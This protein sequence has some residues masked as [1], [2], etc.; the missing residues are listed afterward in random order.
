LCGIVGL[1]G[2]LKPEDEQMFKVLLLLD[3]FRGQDSTGMAVIGKDKTVKVLKTADDPIILMQHEDFELTLHAAVSRG[4]LGHNRA[5]TI[6]GTSRANAHPFTHGSITGVHNGTLTVVNKLE[7]A[8]RLEESYATDSETLYAHMAKYGV[9][10][11]IT[12]LEGAWALVWFNTADNTL[13]MI[14]NAE[15]PLW[16]CTKKSGAGSVMLWAS[17]NEMLSAAA[18]MSK[19]GGDY[20]TDEEGYSYYAL[21]INTL[22]TWN[23]EM[24][25]AGNLTP[26]TKEMKGRPT[27]PKVITPP[28]I[29]GATPPTSVV[30]V[31]EEDKV[32][33]VETEGSEAD[34]FGGLITEAEWESLSGNGCSYCGVNV[35]KHMEGLAIFLPEQIVLCPIC[36]DTPVTTI[37]G[38]SAAYSSVHAH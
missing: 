22:H 3:Y 7:L 28:K 9:E 30:T 31:V 20:D 19:D 2:A 18:A 13:N 23:L 4:F 17:E 38:G 37:N 34:P 8:S 33:T 25:A 35:D 14:R 16:T 32:I 27:P 24:L 36:S 1:A 12:R 11:T 6:G 5:A 29:P 15:R 21:D 26:R 10:D